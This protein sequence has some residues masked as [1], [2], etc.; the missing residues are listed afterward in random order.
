MLELSSSELAGFCSAPLAGNYSAVDSVLES[1]DLIAQ[2]VI[3]F[4]NLNAFT[5]ITLIT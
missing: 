3:S 1:V 2:Q 5:A 4:P